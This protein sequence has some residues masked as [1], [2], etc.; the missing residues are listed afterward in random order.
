MCSSKNVNR[1]IRLERKGKFF[2]QTYSRRAR[3]NLLVGRILLTASRA[4][5]HCRMTWMARR[6]VRALS[7]TRVKNNLTS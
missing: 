3:K 1:I 6:H 2:G 7:V 5:D 4:L